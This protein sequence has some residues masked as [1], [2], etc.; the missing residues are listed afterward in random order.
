MTAAR[1]PATAPS[2]IVPVPRDRPLALSFAQQRLWFVA[3]LD[4]RGCSLNAPFVLTLAGELDIAAL[5][6]AL[7]EIV[8]RHDAL[9]T[10][11]ADDGGVPVQRVTAEIDVA[12][13]LED[14]TALAQDERAAAAAHLEQ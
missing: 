3:Q 1:R 4:P 9:R 14:L 7:R 11:F 8:R 5:H 12:L 10:T 13:P 6:R 2:R